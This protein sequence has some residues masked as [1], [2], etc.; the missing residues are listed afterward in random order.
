MQVAY[1]IKYSSDLGKGIF[2]CENISIGSCVWQYNKNINVLEYNEKQCKKHLQ[3][4]E[5]AEA[6][7]FLD[8]TYGCGDLICQITDD[9]RYMN[10]SIK[11]NCKTFKKIANNYNVYAICEIL[12]GEELFEDYSTFDH[13]KF[14][15][16]LLEKYNCSP[17]YYNLPLL[18]TVKHNNH[19]HQTNHQHN[20]QP[21]YQ[22]RKHKPSYVINKIAN[23]AKHA[24]IDFICINDN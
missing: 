16:S 14:L 10:H 12:I 9:G 6:Q 19:N 22:I 13:P 11:P 24:K 1:E 7:N 17:Q 8:I 20:Y 21:N 4:L 15:C 23:K 3:T 2:A 18:E 5:L